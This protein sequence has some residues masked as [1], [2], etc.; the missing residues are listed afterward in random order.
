MRAI[1]PVRMHPP[2]TARANVRAAL[3]KAV[4][5]EPVQINF[6]SVLHANPSLPVSAVDC[7]EK[8][9]DICSRATSDR[10]NPGLGP[11]MIGCRAFR[12]LQQTPPSTET[13]APGRRAMM[14]PMAPM[15]RI[16]ATARPTCPLARRLTAVFLQLASGYC[17]T[18][19]T[20]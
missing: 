10:A 16:H 6:Q 15:N 18:D 3:D 1:A 11:G 17:H 14:V 5:S 2:N 20:Q 13:P 8:D 12:L 9:G 4:S 7:D 19:Q